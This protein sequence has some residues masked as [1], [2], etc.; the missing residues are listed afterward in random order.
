MRGTSLV[1]LLSLVH[2]CKRK[3]SELGIADQA[4]LYMM[5]SYIF[6]LALKESM[7]RRCCKHYII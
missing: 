1:E 3:K 4:V 7:S 5:I 2:G 6:F